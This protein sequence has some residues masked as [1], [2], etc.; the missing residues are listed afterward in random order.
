M[1]LDVLMKFGRDLLIVKANKLM[2]R[3]NVNITCCSYFVDI[4]LNFLHVY[5]K[6]SSRVWF[7]F[8]FSLVQNPEP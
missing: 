8:R 1:L 7:C 4:C 3:T 2:G 6:E 5:V